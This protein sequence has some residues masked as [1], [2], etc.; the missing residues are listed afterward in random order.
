M[1]RMLRPSVG[2]LLA[3]LELFRSECDFE[4]ELDFF[5]DLGEREGVAGREEEEE[6]EGCCCCCCWRR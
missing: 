5:L 4:A 1:N 6:E 3:L 2:S